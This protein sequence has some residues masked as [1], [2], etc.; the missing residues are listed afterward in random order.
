MIIIGL[1][2]EINQPP[3]TIIQIGEASTDTA[4]SQVLSSFSQIVNPGE[5]LSPKIIQLTGITQAQVDAGV[6]LPSAYAAFL[7]W[8][9]QYPFKSRFMNPLTWGG[10]DAACLRRQLGLDGQWPLGRRILD[11]KTLYVSYC[12]A[13]GAPPKGGLSV[14]M[15]KEGLSFEGTAHDAKDDAVNTLRM[16]FHLQRKWNLPIQNT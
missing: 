1:D 6:S 7:E 11:V 4:T 16:F 10:D 13:Q 12:I 14:S 2:P 15:K 5:I 8:M 9:G 3:S